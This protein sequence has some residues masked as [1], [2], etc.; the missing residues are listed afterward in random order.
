MASDVLGRTNR[1]FPK[2]W[3]SLG[4]P[5]IAS[6]IEPLIAAALESRAPIDVS[7][8]PSLWGQ[9]LR[10]QDPVLLVNGTAEYEHAADESHA[11]D[12]VSA[13][14]IQT[15]SSLGRETIDF[16][17]LPVRRVVEEYQF[18]GVLQSLELARQEGHIRH[19][20]VVSE[21]PGLATLGMWQFHDAFELLVVTRNHYD[22]AAYDTL[23]PVARERRVGVLTKKPLDWGF[24]LPFTSLPAPW[25]LK[26]LTQ[27]M[28]GYSLAQAAIRDLIEDNP[29]LLGVRSAA[30]VSVAMRATEI[31][32]PQGLDS[33]LAPYREAFE[34]EST[35]QS[36]L[37]SS[38]PAERRSAQLRERAG[39]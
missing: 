20:A 33:F 16:Y 10:G 34:S 9:H 26:N 2:L 14:I 7:T 8:Q 31:S 17:C 11:A 27:G 22:H 39:R 25:Q 5:E 12:L 23:M 35:W 6:D 32:R 36:F 3:L 38:D 30:E 28:Y 18:N 24:G 21:G 19:L 4:V 13:H 29:V 15:L 1:V 37:I